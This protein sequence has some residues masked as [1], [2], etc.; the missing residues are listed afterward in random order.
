[1]VT[2]AL[3]AIHA[4]APDALRKVRLIRGFTMVLDLTVPYKE[5]MNDF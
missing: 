1:M 3:D 2:A 4:S 5:G